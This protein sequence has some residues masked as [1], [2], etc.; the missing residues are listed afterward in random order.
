MDKR[1]KYIMKNCFAING[2]SSDIVDWGLNKAGRKKNKYDRYF[3]IGYPENKNIKSSTKLIDK[4]KF[5]ISFFATIN[6]QFNY[7]L[8]YELANTL[9]KEDKNVIINICGDG[10]QF[11]LM[12]AKL[13]NLKNINI[14]GWLTKEKLTE[15]LNNSDIGLAPYKNTFDFQMS[16]SNKF[17]EYI[18]Y[19]LPVI[20]TCSGNMGKILKEN[21][22]GLGSLD[23]EEIT[24]YILDLKNNKKLYSSS[25]MNA[26]N[27]YEKEFVATKVF[28]EMREYIEKIGDEVK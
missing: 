2:T 14:L 11:E 8:I 7:D 16:V 10:P 12:K 1:T 23:I 17:A 15:V 3:Y 19:G 22:C 18:S 9:Y 4:N 26:K 5:N 28:K 25:S 27:L 6:N 20:V 13:S 21:K 24:K